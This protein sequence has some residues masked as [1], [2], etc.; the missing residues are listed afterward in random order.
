MT[1]YPPKARRV[2]RL[3]VFL[4]IQRIDDSGWLDVGDI[5]EFVRLLDEA[6]VTDNVVA[7][8]WWDSTDER[9]PGIE[10]VVETKI[11]PR[12]EP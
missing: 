6:A 5:R 8:V 12:R 10:V 7:R 3:T 2:E 1:T 4:P 9:R 11:D